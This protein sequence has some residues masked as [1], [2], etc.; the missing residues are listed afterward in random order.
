MGYFIVQKVRDYTVVEFTTPS[1][2]D[3]RE[4]DEISEELYKLVDEQDRREI[5]LDFTKVEYVSSQAIGIVMAMHRKLTPLKKS[6]LIL[7]G[8]GPKLLELMRIT[9]LDKVLAI[10]PSQAEATKR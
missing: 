4:L 10:K 3:S 1:L 7:C 6:K 2:M 9:R 8:L 5:V